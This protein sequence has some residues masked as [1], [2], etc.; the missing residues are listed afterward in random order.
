MTAVDDEF[1]EDLDEEDPPTTPALEDTPTLTAQQNAA[2]DS[3]EGGSHVRQC[4]ISWAPI[5]VFSTIGFSL[6]S[7]IRLRELLGV[8]EFQQAPTFRDQ[9]AIA[10]PDLRVFKDGQR[11]S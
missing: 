4:Q 5:T 10:C 8:V 9:A 6:Q 7:Q 3:G 1:G 2:I 11:F